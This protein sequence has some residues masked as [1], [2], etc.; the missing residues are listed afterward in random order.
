MDREPYS[1]EYEPN[2]ED[3]RVEPLESDDETAAPPPTLD[4]DERVE[5]TDDD[6]VVPDE[7]RPV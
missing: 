5:E 3:E 7:D 1:A 6:D 4:P 2:A